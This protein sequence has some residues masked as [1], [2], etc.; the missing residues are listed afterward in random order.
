MLYTE[1]QYPT[2]TGICQKVCVRW[3]GAVVCKPTLVFSLTQA[4]QYKDIVTTVLEIKVSYTNLW[5]CPCL[6]WSIMCVLYIMM[7]TSPSNIVMYLI[8][9]VLQAKG[10]EEKSNPEEINKTSYYRYS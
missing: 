10:W 5:Y 3:C 2:M 4:E 7:N 9:T 6:R 8:Q 1:F